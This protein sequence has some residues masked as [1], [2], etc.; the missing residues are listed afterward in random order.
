L[1]RKASLDDH[2]MSP[3][4]Q[5]KCELINAEPLLQGAFNTDVCTAIQE[6]RDPKALP[7]DPLTAFL[8]SGYMERITKDR[9]A[10][11]LNGVSSYA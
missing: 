3:Q 5:A 8:E 7:R 1:F 2:P 11:S 9:G 4:A 10:R 6:W